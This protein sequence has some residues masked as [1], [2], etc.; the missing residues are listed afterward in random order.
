MGKWVRRPWGFYTI[1]NKGKCFKVK[2][3][4]VLPGKRLGLQSHRYRSE[5][6]VV[7]SGTAKITNG[8]K[9]HDPQGKSELVYSQ[10]D[11]PQVRKSRQE[12]KP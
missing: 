6:W 10:K 11:P 9:Q 4:E 7:V 2:L 5:H 12:A 1:L 3:V 8:G